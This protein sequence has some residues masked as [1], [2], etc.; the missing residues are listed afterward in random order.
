MFRSSIAALAAAIAIAGLCAARAQGAGPTHPGDAAA[1]DEV[2]IKCSGC[3]QVGPGS[4]NGIGPDLDGV[5][6][7]VSGTVPGYD[8]S[9]AMTA[10]RIT[11][12]HDALAA[13]LANPQHGVPG[14]KMAYAGLKNPQDIEDV[15]AYLAGFDAKGAP[16]P[17]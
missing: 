17:R 13:F 14:T 6:G 5:V 10:A 16:L 8:Y 9:P 4:A 3:H 12:D 1:G 11:W 2:F 7:R 15:I